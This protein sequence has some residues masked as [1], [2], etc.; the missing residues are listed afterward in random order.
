MRISDMSGVMMCIWITRT[1]N[2]GD[3]KESYFKSLRNLFLKTT[4]FN[5]VLDD[6]EINMTTKTLRTEKG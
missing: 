3:T 2:G 1:E 5:E 4:G 6:E